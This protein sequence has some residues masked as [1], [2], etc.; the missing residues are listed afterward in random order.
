MR[1][2]DGPDVTESE[3]VRMRETVAA[4]D[5]ET[6]VFV[7]LGL[8]SSIELGGPPF[9]SRDEYVRTMTR[10]VFREIAAR[11]IPETVYWP[12]FERLAGEPDLNLIQGGRT[13]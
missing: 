7:M 10:V 13:D 9:G 11:W 2:A 3:L 1:P 6:L 5:D 4:L 12:A 8:H